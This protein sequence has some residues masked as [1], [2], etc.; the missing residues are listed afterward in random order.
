MSEQWKID[1]LADLVSGA[2]DVAGYDGQRS[3]RVRAVPDPRTIR[4]YTT[5]GLLDRP[6]AMQG[7]TAYYGRRHVLQLVAIK[8]L[9]ARG[10]SLVEVQRCLA[11]ADD[12]ALA[13]WADLP[14]DFWDRA[15]GPRSAKAPTPADDPRLA[16]ATPRRER[17]WAAA[18]E[19]SV[20]A[21]ESSE[22]PAPLPERPSPAP[23]PAPAIQWTLAPGVKL[24]IEGID[25]R[26][27]DPQALAC[28]N[29]L[30]EDLVD[31]L[32]GLGLARPGPGEPENPS[33]EE[34]SEE[35]P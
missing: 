15:A 11:G 24:L 27:L 33:Q 8:R 28:L 1:K 16:E 18:A 35:G 2:L 4:Y 23:S 5:L 7:R 31:V 29:P 9:Q 30:L 21:T 13:R 26:Q 17:F 14:G 34:G 32:R 25:P 20:T 6:A 22:V 10:L 3:G 19:P 12:G